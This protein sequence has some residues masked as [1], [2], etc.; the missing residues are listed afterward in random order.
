MTLRALIR[1]RDPGNHATA[2]PATSAMEPAPTAGTVAG[3]AT[4]AVASSPTG[5]D[6]VKVP[7]SAEAANAETFVGSESGN[8][9][10]AP[11]SERWPGSMTNVGRASTHSEFLVAEDADVAGGIDFWL[12]S[13][14]NPAIA[15]VQDDR[16]YCADCTNLRGRVCVVAKPG[17]VVSATVGYRP[18]TD[19]LQ[20]C[21]GFEERPVRPVP[22]SY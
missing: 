12:S 18:V 9:V 7:W 8:K 11:T 6:L 20:R 5:H 15:Q 17:G 13:D 19:L 14:A 2:I 22:I 3:T 1:K 4:V 16:A 10:P 21:A